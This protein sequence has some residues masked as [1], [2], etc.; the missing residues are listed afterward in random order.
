MALSYPMPTQ[1][2]LVRHIG[3]LLAKSIK[4]DS[5]DKPKISKHNVGVYRTEDGDVAALIICDAAF[6][7]F[8]GAALAMVPAGVA[9]E[10]ARAGKIP[11]NLRENFDEVLNI[12]A[13]LFNREGSPRVRYDK[14]LGAGDDLPEDVAALDGTPE[15]SQDWSADI[16]GYGAGLV[17]IRC[18]DRR[19]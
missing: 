15:E 1:G 2:D 8:V 16:D 10:A 9:Q 19:A 18:A 7:C 17:S 14:L 13:G 3:D 5:A 12:I 11:D 4:I 6:G